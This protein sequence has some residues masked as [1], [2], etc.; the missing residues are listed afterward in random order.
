ML[1]ALAW[2]SAL[3]ASAAVRAH[4]LFSDGAVLQRGMPVPV[5]GTAEEG[6]TVTVRIQDQSA[7]TTANG[8]RWQVRLRPLKAGGPFTLTIAGKETIEAKDVLVGEV[9]LCSGQ[10][11]MEWP[12][13][14][15]YE[16]QEA[17]QGSED[18]Q[19]R[20][21][22]EP[23]AIAGYPLR[24]AR[25][26]WKKCGPES[27]A[28]FSAVAYYFG[29]DLRRALGVPVG[30]I[31]S[32]WGGTPAEAWTSRAQLSAHSELRPI[33]ERH[34]EARL[35]YPDA[36]R[37]HEE[38]MARHRE[39]VA[40][41]E[42]EGRQPPRAPSP[43]S[44]P[45]GPWRPSGL[46]NAMIAPLQPY[47]I[48]GA[49]WYQGESNAGRAYEYRTLFPAMIQGWREAWGQGEFPFLLVQLAPFLAIET[50]PKES[51]WAELREAQ[52]LTT[53]TVPH[54][55]MAVITDAGDERDIHPARKEPVGQRLALAARAVA[56]GERIAYTGPTF[57]T[58]EVKGDRAILRFRNTGKGL[59]VKGGELTGFTICGED[60]KWVNARATLEGDRVVVSSPQVARP[61]AVRFGWANYP[62]VNLYSAE[63]LPASPF[64][65]DD[66]GWSTQR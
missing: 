27:V 40:A 53:L 29:R 57:H 17:I 31:Q 56:Y 23:H 30:L 64:R 38:A 49:I 35:A 25:G 61:V 58:M 36:L 13:T 16:P 42:R 6:E 22:T 20:L 45:D 41:A 52:R 59:V 44:N 5:W 34:R 3:P 18:A 33:L 26:A 8:G 51:A 10:S 63:G 12:L 55:A 46:Y 4:P 19:L 1:A 48:R 50:E 24:E 2:L 54:T 60:H 37:A 9:W 65:T 47:A 66:F 14:R 11:N 39:A 7:T 62:V 43:P 28:G 32:T 15:T 21:W